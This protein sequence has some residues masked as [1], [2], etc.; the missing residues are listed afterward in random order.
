[1][2]SRNNVVAEFVLVSRHFG[3][4]ERS[5]RK[6]FGPLV[7]KIKSKRET[8]QNTKVSM[9]ISNKQNENTDP[10]HF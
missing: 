3:K 9:I 4:V 1:M 10:T 5:V 7:S 2:A 8:Y 6:S